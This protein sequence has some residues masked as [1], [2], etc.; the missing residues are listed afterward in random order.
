[1]VLQNIPFQE[2][3][4]PSAFKFHF[5]SLIVAVLLHQLRKLMLP[6]SYKKFYFILFAWANAEAWKA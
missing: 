6:K 1:M 3:Y 5:I 4:Q 2:K